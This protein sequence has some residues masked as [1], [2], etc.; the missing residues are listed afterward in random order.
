ME[1]FARFGENSLSFHFYF[2]LNQRCYKVV[3]DLAAY[4]VYCIVVG[5]YLV[6]QDTNELLFK[7]FY[8]VHFRRYILSYDPAPHGQ[9]RGLTKCVKMPRFSK[10]NILFK[11]HLDASQTNIK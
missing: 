8:I 10:K 5:E 9:L 1:K 3:Y 4:I 7:R 11:S 2:Y 6:F